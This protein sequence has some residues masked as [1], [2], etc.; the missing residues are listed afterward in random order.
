MVIA[1]HVDL[2][3]DRIAH[4][5]FSHHADDISGYS[6]HGSVTGAIPSVDREGQ[7]NQ[8][9]YF[10][11]VNDHIVCGTQLG[12]ISSAV[13]VSCWMRTDQAEVYSHLVSKYDFVSDGGFILGILD[14]LALWAGRIGSGQY[15][16]L[17]SS[18]RIDDNQWHHILGMVREGIWYIY[19]DGALE[20]QYNTGFQGTNL[21]CSTPLSLG[22][23]YQGDAADHRYYSG[24]LDDVIIYKRGL[25]EC[26]ID[27]LYT[28]NKYG[29][30]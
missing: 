17:T 4:Y 28:G 29:P 10:D 3:R 2:L 8:A 27:A 21:D 18:S 23:Y 30:R 25:N 22:M 15:I 9:Y 5:P 1:Q 19:I 6:N 16:R 11:G 13:T 24:H 7:E 14:G 20:N 12:P 26:E